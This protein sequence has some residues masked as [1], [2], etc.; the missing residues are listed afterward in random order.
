MGRTGTDASE[1]GDSEQKGVGK[2]RQARQVGGRRQ[3]E[4]EWRKIE[5]AL[6][7]LP[8][9]ERNRVPSAVMHRLG[10]NFSTETV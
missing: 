3:K 2:E 9:E 7:P 5:V 4:W 8:C 10:W 1:S 6:G